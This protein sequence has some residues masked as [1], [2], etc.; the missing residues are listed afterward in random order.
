MSAVFRLVRLF[1]HMDLDILFNRDW[2]S[3]ID[4]VE[5]QRNGQNWVNGNSLRKSV[6]SVLN[7]S[8]S[9][10]TIIN[11]WCL[12]LLISS[13]CQYLSHHA[14]KPTYNKLEYIALRQ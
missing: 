10:F 5:C 12:N 2:V 1:D 9:D 7:D 4:G 13:I 8:G 3:D 11:L 14:V 6:V